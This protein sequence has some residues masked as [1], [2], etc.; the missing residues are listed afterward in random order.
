MKTA[1]Y[2]ILNLV[3]DSSINSKL[4]VFLRPKDQSCLQT[5]LK[6]K[7]HRIVRHSAAIFGSTAMLSGNRER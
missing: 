1:G 7:V 6:Q 2:T 5:M 3:F 4:S